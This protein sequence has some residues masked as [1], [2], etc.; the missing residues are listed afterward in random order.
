MTFVADSRHSASFVFESSAALALLRPAGTFAVSPVLTH[1]D[2][3]RGSLF[4]ALG[5]PSAVWALSILFGC[6]AQNTT[7]QGGVAT[8]SEQTP[9]AAPSTSTAPSTAP[10]AEAPSAQSVPST[11]DAA[12]QQS[13]ASPS[14]EVEAAKLEAAKLEELLRIG[15]ELAPV[16]AAYL[17]SLPEVVDKEHAPETLSLCPRTVGEPMIIGTSVRLSPWTLQLGGTL[18]GDEVKLVH[19]PHE[20][21]YLNWRGWLQLN[22]HKDAQGW[23]VSPGG[24]TRG[25]ACKL[26]AQNAPET[27]TYAPPS[28]P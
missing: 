13:A 27:P 12:S 9:S 26:R 11:Q 22:L 1:F 25:I 3:L 19:T 23:H 17:A 4:G 2:L 8:V 15:R 20:L 10:N 16:A 28:K 21:L 14:T 5:T 7:R 24:V 18:A 6:S